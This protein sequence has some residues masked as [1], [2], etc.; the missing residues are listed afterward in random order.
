MKLHVLSRMIMAFSLNGLICD[1]S[2]KHFFQYKA[3]SLHHNMG[4]GKNNRP[5]P[6]SLVPLLH[7]EFKCETV[8]MKM[9]LICMKMKLHAEFI[10]I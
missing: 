8:V 7:S 2:V 1:L 5:F 6:S 10:F 3:I 9:T 4:A